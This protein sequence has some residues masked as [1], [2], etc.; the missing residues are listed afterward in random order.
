[1]H[2]SARPVTDLSRRLAALVGAA[3][4]ELGLRETP[5]EAEAAVRDLAGE[6]LGLYEAHASWPSRLTGSGLPLELSIKL[7][8]GGPSVRCVADVADHRAGPDANQSRYIEHGVRMGVPREVVEDL[9]GRGLDGVPPELPSQLIH[10]LAYGRHRFRASLYLRTAWLRPEELVRRFPTEVAA[11]ARSGRRDPRIEVVG[12][13]FEPGTPTRSKLYVWCPAETAATFTQ[14]AGATAEL[15]PARRLFERFREGAAPQLAE[16]ALLLQIRLDG[17]R[18]MFFPCHAWGWNEA[19][20]AALA[21][22]AGELDVDLAP[23]RTLQGLA[24]ADGLVL[25]PALI[26]VGGEASATLYLWPRYESAP[27]CD[28]RRARDAAIE[29]LVERRRPDGAYGDASATAHV[30]ATL[31]LAGMR[32]AGLAP[33]LGWLRRRYRPGLGWDDAEIT[34]FALEAL[35]RGGAPV[36]DDGFAALV[37]A[38]LE[39]GSF[40][41]HADAEDEAGAPEIT[42]AALSSLLAAYPRQAGT[43]LAAALQ[44]LAEAQPDGGWSARGGNRLL[45]TWRAVRALQAYVATDFARGLG[46]ASAQRAR[47]AI[48]RA[49]MFLAAFAVPREPWSCAL[50]LAAWNSAGGDPAAP[51]AV[52]VMAALCGSQREDGRWVAAPAASERRGDEDVTTAIAAAALHGSLTSAESN[53]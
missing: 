24:A 33:S 52:R 2:T 49:R 47:A 40:R 10:G 15:K 14:V 29:F 9:C 8:A 41:A 45:A 7:E 5:D 13:D 11:L 3:T 22:L 25:D 26:A 50:W 53:R 21:F 31:A 4:V 23:F 35:A 17:T 51:E 32:A 48:E 37:R 1:M 27:S 19:F 18:R 42:A 20:E 34:A 44:L 16:H 46:Q 39:D 28:P 38:R 6:A 30:T 12:Y 36:P 43:L